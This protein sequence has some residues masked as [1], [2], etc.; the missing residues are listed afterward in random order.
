MEK[1]DQQV[2]HV[3]STDKRSLLID[4]LKQLATD[5]QVWW[6]RWSSMRN[7]EPFMEREDIR[8]FMGVISTPDG[9]HRPIMAGQLDRLYHNNGDGKFQDVTNRSGIQGYDIGLAA[10]WWDYN[11][12]GLADLYVANDFFAT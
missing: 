8:E 10:T 7:L 6:V 9:R 1:I 3:A 4:I 11:Q 5:D 2:C 12:D